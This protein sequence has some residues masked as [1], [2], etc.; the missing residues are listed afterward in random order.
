MASE[1]FRNLSKDTQLLGEEGSMEPR[2]V[3]LQNPLFQWSV[4]TFIFLFLWGKLLR[5]GSLSVLSYYMQGGDT[6][7]GRIWSLVSLLCL[8][9]SADNSR[10]VL[11]R[12]DTNFRDD[13]ACWINID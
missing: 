13:G 7:A 8:E 4:T 10:A 2:F 11:A 6:E 1:K 3:W 5:G 12:D 9:I